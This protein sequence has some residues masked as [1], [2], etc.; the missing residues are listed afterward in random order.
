MLVGCKYIQRLVCL[1]ELQAPE[2]SYAW[3]ESSLVSNSLKVLQVP[4]VGVPTATGD[5]TY[6]YLNIIVKILCWLTPRN[7]QLLKL[8]SGKLSRREQSLIKT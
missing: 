3:E 1:S 5:S 8:K 2:L 7:D 4:A 6:F